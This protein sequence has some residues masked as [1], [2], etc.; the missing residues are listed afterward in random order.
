LREL[1]EF[2]KMKIDMSMEILVSG[3]EIKGKIAI[4]IFD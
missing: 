1:D 4:G 3:G 2:S